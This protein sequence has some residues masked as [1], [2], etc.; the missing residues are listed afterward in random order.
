PLEQMR[1][2]MRPERQK[3]EI[4]RAPMLRLQVASVERDGS[5]YA[6]LQIHHLACD[7]ESLEVL[8]PEVMALM[9]GNDGALTTP[10]PYR[11]HVAEALAHARGRDAEAFFRSKLADVVELAP[12]KCFGI[13]S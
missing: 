1:E 3:L 5:K 6:L 7:H 11:E 8:L 9:E 10:E 13:S 4:S 2:R 12:E